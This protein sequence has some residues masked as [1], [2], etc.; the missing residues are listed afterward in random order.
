MC[1]GSLRQE[2]SSYVEKL[3][4]D[5]GHR[6]EYAKR[7]PEAALRCGETALGTQTIGPKDPMRL[8]GGLAW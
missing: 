4:N 2:H 5:G 3:R 8:G 7:Y 1:P 6:L